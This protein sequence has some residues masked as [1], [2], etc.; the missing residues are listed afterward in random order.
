MS[1]PLLQ[2]TSSSCSEMGGRVVRCSSTQPQLPVELL[3]AIFQF[4]D[5]RCSPSIHLTSKA[6]AQ[7]IRP[8][9][10]SHVVMYAHPRW[11]VEGYNHFAEFLHL[12]PFV[13]WV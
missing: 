2:S 8:Y 11:F 1:S 9:L 6:F 5:P 12:A 7:I 4:C 10:F 3:D 13:R